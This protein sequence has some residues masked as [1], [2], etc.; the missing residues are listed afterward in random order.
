VLTVAFAAAAIMLVS[1]VAAIH[2]IASAGTLIHEAVG[3]VVQSKNGCIEGPEARSNA[4]LFKLDRDG[5]TSRA[6]VLTSS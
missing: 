5:G 3:V 4:S 2:L 6:G 1:L